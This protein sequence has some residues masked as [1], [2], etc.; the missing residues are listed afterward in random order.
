MTHLYA[1]DEGDGIAT[2]FQLAEL[3]QALARVEAAGLYP[4]WLSVGSSPTVSRRHGQPTSSTSPP[5]TA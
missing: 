5:A 2:Q 1:A 3:Q 4:D